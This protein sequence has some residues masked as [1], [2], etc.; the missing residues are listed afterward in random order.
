MKEITYNAKISDSYGEHGAILIEAEC[1][2]VKG[3]GI[4]IPMLVA[5]TSEFVF[6]IKTQQEEAKRVFAH[7]VYLDFEQAMEVARREAKFA[8]IN[9]LTGDTS[10]LSL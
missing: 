4:V 8:V 10:L 9:T 1:D 7:Q 6:R 3:K 5:G 2:G